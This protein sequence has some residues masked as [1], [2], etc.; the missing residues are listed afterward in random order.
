MDFYEIMSIFIGIGFFVNFGVYYCFI[1]DIIEWIVFFLGNVSIFCFINIG[2][3][4]IMGIEFN[5]K[6]SLKN[7]VSLNGDF[8]YNYFNCKG[9]FEVIFFDFNVDC[10]ISCLMIKLKLFV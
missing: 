3:E 5:F 2:I 1:I 9:I 4:G 7:W 8:N 10:W 6:Y